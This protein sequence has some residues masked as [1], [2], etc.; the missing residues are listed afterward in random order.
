MSID[1]PK[2]PFSKRYGY[3]SKPKEIRVWEGAPENLRHF[4]LETASEMGYEPSAIRNLIC[5]VVHVR[6]D[7]G[8]WSEY[9]NVRGEAQELVYGC[10]WFKF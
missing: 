3:R 4:V 2:K 6:P 1:S 10:D 5:S 9:P 8:N 7:P